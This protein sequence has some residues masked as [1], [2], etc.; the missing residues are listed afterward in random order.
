MRYADNMP[1]QCDS[2]TPAETEHN[3][4][5]PVP[6]RFPHHLSQNILFSKYSHGNIMNHEE[7]RPRKLLLHKRELAK[8]SQK[9]SEQGYS[10]VP[11]K[12]YLKGQLVKVE[13]GV[14]RGKKMHDKRETQK[15]RDA[16]REMARALRRNV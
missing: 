12:V 16:D 15:S 6:I 8:L 3:Q 13:I 1:Q 5:F 4:H 11:L 10:V 9:K 14:A 2:D 7:V